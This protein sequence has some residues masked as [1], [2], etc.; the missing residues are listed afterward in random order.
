MFSGEGLRTETD[1]L[2]NLSSHVITIDSN[3]TMIPIGMIET[4]KR[5]HNLDS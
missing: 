1:F 2:T 3:M 5:S 4:M